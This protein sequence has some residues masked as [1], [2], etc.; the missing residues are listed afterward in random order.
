MAPQQ[1]L[2]VALVTNIPAPYRIPVYNQLAQKDGISL[3]V[4]YFA[5]REPDRAWDLAESQFSQTHLTPRYLSFRGRYIHYTPGVWRALR[6]CAPQLVISTGFNPS[7]LM[8]YAYARWHRLPHIAMTD[9]TLTSERGLSAAHRLLRRHVYA[10][11]QAFI[12]ASEGSSLLFADYGV[13]SQRIFRAPL[14]ADNA[15]FARWRALNPAPRSYDF[16]FCGRF[17]ETK[18]PLFAIEVAEHAARRLG[19]KTSLLFVGSGPLEPS[20]RAAARNAADSVRCTFAGFAA[21]ADLPRHYASARLHLFPTLFDP[22]GVVANEACAAGLP[23]LVAKVA[24]C[25]DELVKDG[26][27]GYVLPLDARRWASAAAQLLSDLELYVQ[28]S[29][30]SLQRVKSFSYAHAAEGMWDAITS[31]HPGTTP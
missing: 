13:A 30:A 17:V 2:R 12:G 23:V 3:H 1:T 16:I 31:L 11:S 4:I 21:Q 8:A 9:G 18:Q 27:N 25:A 29:D 14:C 26:V 20:M 7:H 19:R 6:A 15:A 5:G 10:N 22:W 24:G 28:F